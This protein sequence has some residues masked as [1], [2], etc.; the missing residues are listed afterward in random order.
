[1][2]NC[3]HVTYN[4]KLFFYHIYNNTYKS[5]FVP[6]LL[7]G[8]MKFG[9]ESKEDDM[10]LQELRKQFWPWAEYLLETCRKRQLVNKD[11]SLRDYS[12]VRHLELLIWIRDIGIQV[13]STVI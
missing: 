7:A 8:K 9:V 11:Y 1:M 2:M 3:F 6:R 5:Y 10:D 12:S 4:N 13:L